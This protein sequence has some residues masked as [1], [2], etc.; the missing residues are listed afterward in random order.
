M[1]YGTPEHSFKL[2]FQIGIGVNDKYLCQGDYEINNV[3]GVRFIYEHSFMNSA[4]V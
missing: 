3:V 1:I 2:L 4:H